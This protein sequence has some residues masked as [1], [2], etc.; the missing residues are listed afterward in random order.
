MLKEMTQY[1]IP[2]FSDYSPKSSRY[3]VMKCSIQQEITSQL[4][5]LM[6]GLPTQGQRVVAPYRGLFI[7][8]VI[9]TTNPELPNRHCIEAG[10]LP[11]YPFR[12]WEILQ[13]SYRYKYLQ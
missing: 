3:I 10:D 5:L 7:T 9:A 6:V 12:K 1:T 8:G 11:I 13:R 2:Y 4:L